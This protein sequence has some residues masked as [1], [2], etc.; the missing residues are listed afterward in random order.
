M[1]W[2][3][4]MICWA[5]FYSSWDYWH[6]HRFSDFYLCQ[7]PA[8]YHWA[9]SLF[10]SSE[11][12]LEQGIYQWLEAGEVKLGSIPSCP[13]RS[14]LAFSG[15]WQRVCPHRPLVA[16]PHDC[17]FSQCGFYAQ[18][19]L[20]FKMKDIFPSVHVFSKSQ[21]KCRSLNIHS[22]PWLYILWLS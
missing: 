13:S 16:D 11:V 21:I 14:L 10:S 9:I 7:W 20:V 12:K 15:V 19:F 6:F 17:P 22:I 5:A 2:Q 4:H 3:L 8:H 18:G 1:S